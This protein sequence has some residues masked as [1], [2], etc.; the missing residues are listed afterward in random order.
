MIA[1]IKKYY[2]R[3]VSVVLFISYGQTLFMLP[4]QDDNA[5]F[6]KLAH[7]QAPAGFLGA[8]IFGE[9]AYKYTAFFYYPIY[10]IFGYREFFYFALA[11]LMYGA[12]VFVVYKIISKILDKNSGIIAGFLYACGFI[13][14]DGYIRLFNSFITSLSVILVL[15]FVYYY[16]LFFKITGLVKKYYFLSLVFFFLAAEF[17]RARTPY[18][19]FIPLVFEILSHYARKI[20]LKKVA[21][22]ILRMV[23]FF[24][25]FYK[26]VILEDSR[27]GEAMVFV[28]SII[29]GNF[30]NTFG[31]FGTFSNLF[32]PSWTL[33]LITS[34]GAF[35]YIFFFMMIALLIYL[36]FRN[37]KKIFAGITV[38]FTVSW[39][40][41]SSKIYITP[42][43]T[44][45]Q[46]QIFLA[47]LGGE[48][49]YFAILTV[50]LLEKK[51]RY[52]YLVFLV[53]ILVN[54]LSYSAYFPNLAYEKINRYLAHSFL[55]LICLFAVLIYAYRGSK[56]A[57]KIIYV[58]LI[59]WGIGNLADSF[60]YQRHI[61]ENR[62]APVRSFY[63]ELK[64][65]LAKVNNGDVLFFDVA[66]NARANFADAF[67]VA[68]M[69][70]ATAIAWRYGVDRYDF[71][72]FSDPTDFFG[73]LQTNKIERKSLHTFYYSNDGLIDTTDKL[74]SLLFLKNAFDLGSVSASGPEASFNG[75]LIPSLVPS[76]LVVEIKGIPL[77]LVS[78]GQLTDDN[79]DKKFI[80]L[81]FDYK[82]FKE[83]FQKKNIIVS[84]DWQGRV[85]KNLT[86]DDNSTVWEADR[87]LWLKEDQYLIMNLGDG[88]SYDRLAFVNAY[89]DSTPLEFDI[90]SSND[91]KN[92][93]KVS[94]FR[95][96]LRFGNG[97]LMVVS[98]GAQTFNYLKISFKKTLNDDAPAISEIWPVPAIFSS[99]DIT[100][101]EEF[102]LNPF[103]S[104]PNVNI[105]NFIL[106]ENG[107]VGKVDLSWVNNK[108]FGWQKSAQ[109]SVPIVFD[110]VNRLYEIPIP[111][112]GTVIDKLKLTPVN[113]PGNISVN[114]K[115]VI[116]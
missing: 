43:L 1:F 86:D 47:F 116:Y 69:P 72:I 110:G 61:L 87:L 36:L 16:W 4:W 11:F 76:R 95:N 10:L 104:V 109:S 67:S 73:Y 44:V 27:S 66:D 41:I 64:N 19:V 103:A 99:L 40:I 13:A 42:F 28:K 24:L 17:A 90:L 74:A 15:V 97:G 93:S 29:T 5:L 94:T 98:F 58:I 26:Y 68:Q 14:S 22:S 52:L 80:S 8:G 81:A 96:S 77:G 53:G 89:S 57:L 111:A 39:F 2:W 62:T 65:D 12:S 75:L 50:F 7:I 48:L 113:F 25:I 35:Y 34:N 85:S 46:E 37:G 100:K 59:L 107:Y 33:N 108:N 82:R 78:R 6:F 91:S 79:L 31:F 51:H 102:I 112:G 105:Y 92:W 20:S 49:L 114:L 101:T 106:K 60:I 54:I 45:S 30:Y 83:L 21:M 56:K 23:P 9:K 55:Y 88:I 71:Q 18:L 84:S 32:L 70:D 115:R 38:L 63:Q 3:A